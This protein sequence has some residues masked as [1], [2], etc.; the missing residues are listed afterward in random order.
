MDDWHVG[1]LLMPRGVRNA[2]RWWASLFFRVVLAALGLSLAYGLASAQLAKPSNCSQTVGASA[3]PTPFPTSGSGPPFPSFYLEICNAHATNTLGLNWVGGTASIG[4]Q[5]T[6]TLNPG[7]CK[8]WNQGAIPGALS[9]IGS[10]ASTTT[11]CGY[12]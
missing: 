7:G 8:W 9:V 12:H 2:G 11:A 4:A 5:G 10:G 3:A 1:D 6:L